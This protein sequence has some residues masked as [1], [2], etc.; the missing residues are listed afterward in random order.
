MTCVSIQCG[1]VIDD[2]VRLMRSAAA[3][4]EECTIFVCTGRGS[5]KYDVC[6]FPKLRSLNLKCNIPLEDILHWLVTPVLLNLVLRSDCQFWHDSTEDGLALASFLK[7]LASSYTATSASSPIESL[8]LQRINMKQP[9]LIECLE[10]T[11]LLS[12][13]EVSRVKAED[14]NPIGKQVFD[15]LRWQCHGADILVPKLQYFVLENC[16]DGDASSLVMAVNQRVNLESCL[17]CLEDGIM[18][19]TR[20]LRALR[21]ALFQ[22]QVLNEMNHQGFC[23]FAKTHGLDYQIGGIPRMDFTP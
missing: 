14:C 12:R 20:R 10:K 23:Y 22:D 21:L 17:E 4:L 11:P 5:V 7:E 15:R 8:S 3:H 19:R 6:T 9:Q 13:L 16:I 2:A 1:V 18:A